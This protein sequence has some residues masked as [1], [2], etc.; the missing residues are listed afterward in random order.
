MGKMEKIVKCKDFQKWKKK[1]EKHYPMRGETSKRKDLYPLYFESGE[2]KRDSSPTFDHISICVQKRGY[3]RKKE[4]LS[5]RRWK[6]K[7][8]MK[9]EGDFNLEKVSEEEIKKVSK[10]AID[11]ESLRKKIKVLTSVDGI[12]LRSATAILTMIYPK[13]YCVFDWRVWQT[14]KEIEED[15]ET[16]KDTAQDESK[17]FYNY[18]EFLDWT[19][20]KA[21]NCDM[22]PREIDM[23]L[24]QFNKAKKHKK[25]AEASRGQNSKEAKEKKPPSLEEFKRVVK[26]Y[27]EETEEALISAYSKTVK[28]V[29]EEILEPRSFTPEKMEQIIWEFLRTWGIRGKSPN[30]K[31][32]ADS[33]S[34]IVLELDKNQRLNMKL[35]EFNF[36]DQTKTR[37]IKTIYRKLTD[38]NRIGPTS[39]SMIIHL[40]NPALFLMW[41]RK[42]REFHNTGKRAE[43]YIAF[44]KRMKNWGKELQKSPIIPH[45][46]EKYDRTLAK[47]IDDYNW[48]IT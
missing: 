19:K 14:Y 47:L 45:L 28:R 17:E 16:D 11:A 12:A 23:A 36:D 26:K 5:I 10:K 27:E 30:F 22:T 29:K 33:L 32:L 37:K 41:N 24:W 8:G 42:I 43:H 3:L 46:M 31:E 35:L 25:Q 13:E 34:E 2:V 7:R 38:I 48:K 20:Q 6:S 39:A 21:E 9:Q 15:K 1:Y 4:F 18:R 44:S 40:L